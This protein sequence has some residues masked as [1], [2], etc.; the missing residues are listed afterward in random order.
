[1][2]RLE[3]SS[4]LNFHPPLFLIFFLSIPIIPLFLFGGDWGRWVCISITFTTLF[5]FFLYKNNLITV[6][7]KNISRKLLFL[8]NKRKIVTILFILFAFTWNQKTT[9]REDVA[10]MPF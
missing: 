4:K 6:D 1:M 3:Q 2:N 5:Y 10:T 9:L 8:K 7:Y